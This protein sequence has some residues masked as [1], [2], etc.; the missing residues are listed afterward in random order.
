M[1]RGPIVLL[2]YGIVMILG[3]LIG[4]LAGSKASLISGSV[5]GVLLLGAWFLAR[6]HPALGLWGGV[7]LS[8]L[9]SVVF[10]V[11]LAKTGKPMPAANIG[12]WNTT[13]HLNFTTGNMSR[14]RWR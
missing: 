6:D 1:S 8:A 13:R 7:V 4:Y 3:G 2:V 9:L 14:R 5:S 12:S 11:R 10:G